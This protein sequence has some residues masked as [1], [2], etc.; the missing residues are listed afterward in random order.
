MKGIAS[1]YIQ[2]QITICADCFHRDV[3]SDKDY[4]TENRCPNYV[5][6]SLCV[7]LPCKV[8]GTVYFVGPYEVAEMRVGNV[9]PAGRF[10]KGKL[11]NAYLVTDCTYQCVTFADFGKTVFLTREEAEAALK[12]V[13]QDG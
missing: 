7:V 3:C 8:G 6:K 1:G 4:L 13:K 10:V 9:F 11:C 12:E 2:P 5:D